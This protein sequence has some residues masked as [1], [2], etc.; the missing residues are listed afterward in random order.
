MAKKNFVLRIDPEIYNALERWA[1][2]EFR[3][4]NGQVEYILFQSLKNAGRL[5]ANKPQ[6]KDPK[7]NGEE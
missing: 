6:N 4:I 2:D 3:S 1:S 7:S 5:P